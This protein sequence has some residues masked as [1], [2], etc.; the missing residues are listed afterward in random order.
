METHRGERSIALLVAA[1]ATIAPVL[2]T[3]DLDHQ[4][5]LHAGKIHDEATDG[6]L[7]PKVKTLQRWPFSQPVPELDLLR[8]HQAA[9]LA[10]Q[11]HGLAAFAHSGPHPSGF[12]GHP[13]RKRGGIR[14]GPILPR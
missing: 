7:S 2:R 3:I 11:H 4:T 1:A 12:A 13:P 5:S 14:A 6:R 10:S 8:C 9:Q